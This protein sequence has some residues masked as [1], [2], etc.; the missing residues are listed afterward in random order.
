MKFI[1]SNLHEA[2]LLRYKNIIAFSENTQK[3]NPNN[4]HGESEEFR[5]KIKNGS[6]TMGALENDVIFEKMYTAVF[7]RNGYDCEALRK[8]AITE[9]LNK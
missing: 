1:N 6:S 4:I 7:N 8:Q 2:T 5:V 9:Y 3:L